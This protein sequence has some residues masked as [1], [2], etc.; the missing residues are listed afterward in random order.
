[1]AARVWLSVF[2]TKMHEWWGNTWPVSVSNIPAKLLNGSSQNFEGRFAIIQGWHRVTFIKIASNLLPWWQK[3]VFWPVKKLY[4]CLSVTKIPAKLELASSPN[5]KGLF[6]IIR[7]RHR[8]NFIKIVCKLL[9]WQRKRF[10]DCLMMYMYVCLS[11]RF[12]SKYCTDR[13]K[14]FRDCSLSFKDDRA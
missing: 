3:N 5:L 10:C 14:I 12:Q 11:A 6:I 7:G 1:M 8:I 4:V 13:L 9:P 2:P